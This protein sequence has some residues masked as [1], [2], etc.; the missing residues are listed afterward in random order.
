M[1]VK[2]FFQCLKQNI[3]CDLEYKWSF[4]MSI[5]GNIFIFTASYIM[6]VSLFSKFGNIKGFTVYEVLFCFGIMNFG[7][8]FNEL[9]FR[10]IDHFE[11]FIIDGSL[12][13]LLVRPQN[14]LFQVICSKTDFAKITRLIYAIIL[15][16]ISLIN[17]KI[18]FNIIK[19]ITFILM[20]IA[21]ISI[22]F[23]IFLIAASYCFI[24]VKG[25]EVKNLFTDGG[26]HM[27]QYP[28]SIFNKGFILFFTFIIPYGLVNYYPLLYLTNHSQNI[29]Y[30][31]CPIFVI[32]FIIPSILLFNL[33]LKKYEST[34]A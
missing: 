21:S 5:I 23:S 18:K 7:F 24:T 17:L 22:F 20:I 32:L 4:I 33:G 27:A 30:A 11:Q 34:G 29:L 1:A 14:V 3:K 6:I 16:V 10:G 28:I 19:L 31:I 13:R 8:I 15:I 2:L 9:F 25:L 12:D 26:K